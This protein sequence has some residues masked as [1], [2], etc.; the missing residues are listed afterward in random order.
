MRGSNA[1]GSGAWSEAASRATSDCPA[2]TLGDGT[3]PANAWLCLES[4]DARHEVVGLGPLIA[5]GVVGAVIGTVA[6]V[7]LPEDPLLILL[8]AT[9][10]VFVIRFLR[11]P[12]LRLSP[13][14]IRRGGPLVGLLVGILQGAIGVSG[15]V[16]ATWIAGYRLRPRAF[17]HAVTLIFGVTG[18]TQVVVLVAQG[19]FTAELL[20]GA[21]CA[22]LA[23]AVATPLGL[24]LRGRLAGPAFDRVVLIVLLVSALSLLI[25]VVR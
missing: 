6:L 3:D 7:N 25:D 11:N 14:T 23:V 17:V 8:A 4:R 2:T 20:G 22:G 9:V 10:V 21:A 24:R 1:S 15:P 13:V 16:V 12:D 19:R 5:A 18:L